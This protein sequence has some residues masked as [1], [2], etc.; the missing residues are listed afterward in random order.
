MALPRLKPTLSLST[1][2]CSNRHTDG[3]AMLQEMAGLGFEYVELSH[4]I[5]IT[6]VPGILRAIEE[7][8]V[9]VGS[10]HNFCPL[11]T[12]I[13]HAAPNLFEPSA[14]DSR[15]HDQWLRHTKRSIDFAAQVKA[16]VLVCHLGSVRFFWFNPAGAL[17]RYAEHHPDMKAASDKSYQALLAK[18]LARLRKRMGP[19]WDQTKASVNEILAYAAEKKVKLGFENR[20]KFEELPLDGDYPAF[21]DG[22]PPDAS[23]GYWHDTGHADIKQTMGLLDHRQH[24]QKMAPRLIGFHL[25]DVNKEGR[26][27]QPVG[28]GEIDFQMVSEF[29][30]PE[31]L[32]VIEL[33]Q[34]IDV[35][36]VIAS[37]DRVRALMG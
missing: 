4:G 3:Y 31:H 10:A 5:R 20:E 24:L 12:G 2:W 36:G 33:S 1:S 17:A 21:L 13:T 7:G 30:R 26:D 8:V 37:R 34:R 16:R 28:S 11:P 19:F 32:L 14:L 22:L 29:W 25:H 6:L 9:K 23:A 15:E 27:H 35:E 18:S